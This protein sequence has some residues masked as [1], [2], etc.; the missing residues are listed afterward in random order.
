[1]EAFGEQGSVMT[2]SRA[3]MPGR[4]RA[5]VVSVGRLDGALCGTASTDH[6]VAGPAVSGP[7][8]TGG[9]TFV[10]LDRSLSLL[11]GLRTTAPDDLALA[12]VRNAADFA[13]RVEYISR[14]VEYLQLVGAGAGDHICRR[15]GSCR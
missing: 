14:T 9:G 1:M 4:G 6:A 7:V 2:G 12:G 10:G 5:A 8:E 11:G 3:A 13:A 15:P